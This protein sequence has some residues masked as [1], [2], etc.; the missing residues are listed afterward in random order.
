MIALHMASASV[1]VIL[2]TCMVSPYAARLAAAA[3]RAHAAAMDAARAEYRRV[4]GR[5]AKAAGIKARE[6]RRAS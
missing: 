1:F 2:A 4:F 3:L 6:V 5:C